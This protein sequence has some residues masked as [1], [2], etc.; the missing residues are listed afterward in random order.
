MKNKAKIAVIAVTAA[1]AAAVV[2]LVLYA[3]GK[4]GNIRGTFG[5]VTAIRGGEDPQNPAKSASGIKDFNADAVLSADTIKLFEDLRIESGKLEAANTEKISNDLYNSLSD[6][7]KGYITFVKDGGLQD[8]NDYSGFR[9]PDKIRSEAI[10][11]ASEEYLNE[12]GS[13]LLLCLEDDVLY[14]MGP[15]IGNNM[16][17]NQGVL[18]QIFND[19][20]TGRVMIFSGTEEIFGLYAKVTG[21]LERDPSTVTVKKDGNKTEIRC[22][23]EVYDES[24]NKKKADILLSFDS[25]KK[26]IEYSTFTLAEG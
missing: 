3:N 5:N 8:R 6:E 4:L 15:A 14:G 21:L 24:D 12:E 1:V 9:S 20:R 16:L 18:F 2:P 7:S 25:E 26:V 11:E 10:K 13:N 17:F 22:S 19:K 23:T